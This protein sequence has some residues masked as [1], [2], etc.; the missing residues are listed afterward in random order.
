MAKTFSPL[1]TNVIEGIEEVKG[2][3][4]CILDLRELENSICDF[5]V[6]C[7]GNSN[8]QVSAIYNSVE[9]IVR[10]KSKDKPWHVEGQDN[11]TWILMDYVSVAVHIF[12]KETRE[13]YDIEG[14][15]G[16]AEITSLKN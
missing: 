12:Q 10:E 7:E 4:I 2:E 3:N 1:V 9:K 11:A 8:T 5:F 6:I 16:D 15:W 14:L 13:F